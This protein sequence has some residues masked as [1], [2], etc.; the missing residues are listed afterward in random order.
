MAK[1]LVIINVT[2]YLCVPVAFSLPHPLSHLLTGSPSLCPAKLR[3]SCFDPGVVLN[4][5]RLGSDY[6]L[7]STVT[8][9]CEAGY[10]LQVQ[11][12]IG[13]MDDWLI[14]C[15]VVV[16]LTVKCCFFVFRATLLLP[17]VWEMMADLDG[18]GHCLVVKVT[19]PKTHT[20]VKHHWAH[21][22]RTYFSSPLC[23][24]LLVWLCASLPALVHTCMFCLQHPVEVVLRDQKGLFYLQTSP[25]IIPLDRPVS[26]L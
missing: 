26:T 14:G 18:T 4:G 13:W 16:F 17:A 10:V 23:Y 24:F 12:L 20:F 8:F 15:F 1:D 6:K 22:A 7:G 19:H 9:Y 5:T 2:Y 21:T 3:E 25:E 11:R